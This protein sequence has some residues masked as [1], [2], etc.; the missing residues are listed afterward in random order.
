MQENPKE[1]EKLLND[2]EA[3][4]SLLNFAATDD[5]IEERMNCSTSRSSQWPSKRALAELRVRW[6]IKE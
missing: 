6:T 1:F 3:L 5:I 2:P 4:I